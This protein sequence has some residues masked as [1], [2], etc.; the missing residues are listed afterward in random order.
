[1]EY[2]LIRSSRKTLAAEI[3]QGRLIVR[4]PLHAG[5]D[6]IEAFL[7]QHRR[8]IEAHTASPPPS[9]PCASAAVLTE[10]QLR[11]LKDRAGQVIP[12]RAAYYAQK[13]GVT[14]GR[15]TIRCQRTKWGSCSSSGNLNFNCLLMLAPP[16]VLDSVVVHE[17]CHLLEM[18]HSDR[19]YAHVLRLFP[20]YQRWDRWLKQ[21]GS[22]LMA[23]LP[24]GDASG[25]P[26]GG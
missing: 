25:S 18:N 8:W 23:M 19:F 5:K 21:N 12:P 6:R 4:A 1:M 2:Q 20:D 15:V 11:R 22:G 3:K 13:L 10:D 14:F 9:G 7:R 24:P 16:E 26:K 17:V